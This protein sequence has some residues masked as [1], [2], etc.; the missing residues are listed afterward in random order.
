M[1][2]GSSMLMASG[3][4]V[5]AIV[6]VI[7]LAIIAGIVALIKAGIRKF[8]KDSILVKDLDEMGKGTRHVAWGIV[9]LLVIAFLVGPCVIVSMN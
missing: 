7:V 4:V 3:G 2:E 9:I 1:F 8:N 5:G 6:P